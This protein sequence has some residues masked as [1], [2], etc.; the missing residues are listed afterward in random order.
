MAPQNFKELAK[1]C[2][3]SI[4]LPNFRKCSSGRKMV[5]ILILI[6]IV[7]IGKNFVSGIVF[8]FVLFVIRSL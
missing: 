1:L 7:S 6:K 5:L 4:C 3:C 8:S 2:L